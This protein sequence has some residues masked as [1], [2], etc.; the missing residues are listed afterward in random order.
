M[1]MRALLS[2]SSHGS[3]LSSTGCTGDAYA[4]LT[5]EVSHHDAHDAFNH[6]Y[7][8]MLFVA[9]L[10][11]AG[12]LVIRLGMPA[13]VGEIVFGIILG[14]HLL[15]LAGDEG[16]EF[17]IVIGE[18]GLIMLV[19]EAGIDVDVGMLKLIGPRGVAIAVFGSVIPMAFGFC[20][21]YL[22][23]A[24]DIKTSIAIG[25][26]FAPT[27]MGIALNV[28]KKAKILNTPTGQLIIAAAILDDVIALMILSELQAMKEPTVSNILIPLI[29]SPILILG[30]GYLAIRWIPKWI[31]AL[32]TK[33]PKEHHEN[34][35]L[36][37]LFITTFAFV[38]MC[39][40]LGSSHLLGAFLAGLCF[41]TDHT[42]HHV[43]HHQIKRVLQWMLRIFFAA[44]IGFAIPITEFTS[45]AVIIRGLVYCICGIGKIVTGFFA[46]P[47]NAREFFTVGFSMSAWGEFAFILATASYAEGTIDKESFSAVLLA[48]LLSVIYSPYALSFNISY[49]EKKSKQKMDDSIKEYEDKNVHPLYFAINTKAEGHWG[50]QDKILK[51]LFNLNLEIID[52]RSWHAPEFNYTSHLPLTKESFYVQDIVTLLPPTK[53]LDAAEKKLLKQRVKTIRAELRE[54]LGEN[55]VINVKRW[56]PGVTK[57]DDELDPTDNYTKAMFGGEYKPKH[58]KSAEYCRKQAF[59]QAHSMISGLERRDTLEDIARRSRADLDNMSD[60]DQAATLRELGKLQSLSNLWDAVDSPRTPGSK[61][62]FGGDSPDGN[63]ATSTRDF[64]TTVQPSAPHEADFK[65]KTRDESYMSYI[66]GEEDSQNKLA[67][68]SNEHQNETVH[69]EPKLPGLQEDDP[70]GNSGLTIK[71]YPPALEAVASRSPGADSDGHDTPHFE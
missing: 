5:E 43:W 69:F 1:A 26:C 3:E 65:N 31:K 9:S 47:L 11:F 34:T 19:V 53:H 12:K 51:K 45:A 30:I 32:M 25:A 7:Y 59:K 36:A 61:V 71:I 6:L 38:P 22:T 35:I 33:I 28:L 70:Q 42:I 56:L 8:V 39:H 29:V 2:S 60:F 27:S 48:V 49:F 64:P 14:P 50:H 20:M 58:K 13:L 46:R 24:T 66:Y 67:E 16:S 23:M 62:S 52:F 68:Y 41:C 18:I 21:S 10:W 57:S 44:T 37:L 40:F 4:A 55:A 15:N 17:L 54:C 63:A